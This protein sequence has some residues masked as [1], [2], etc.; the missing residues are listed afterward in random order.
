MRGS[1]WW[2]TVP[3]GVLG[4]DYTVCVLDAI[5]A[6][7]AYYDVDEYLA[8]GVTFFGFDAPLAIGTR[9]DHVFLL[10]LSA[11]AVDMIAIELGNQGV[12]VLSP[13]PALYDAMAKDAKVIGPH[14]IGSLIPGASNG[15]VGMTKHAAKLHSDAITRDRDCLSQNIVSACKTY[16]LHPHMGSIGG[17]RKGYACEYGWKLPGRSG[18]GHASHS[19]PGLY[20]VQNPQWAHSYR[21]FR[22]YSMGAV[23]VMREGQRRDGSVVDMREHV[24]AQSQ[25]PFILNPDCRIPLRTAERASRV[26]VSRVPF[27]APVLR[28]GSSGP[29]VATWQRILMSCGFDLAPYADDGDFGKLTHNA[30][31]GFQKERGLRASGVVNDTTWAMSAAAPIPR[32]RPTSD[33]TD[34]ILAK[35]FRWADRKEVDNICIHTIEGVEA[36]TTADRTAMW[37]QG[38]YT[39]APMAS[40]HYLFDDD[41]TI[42]G[43]PE[44]HIAF[45]APGLNHNGIHFEHAGY[46]RQTLEQW[47]DPFGRRMLSRSAKRAA[48]CCEAWD[49][50]P[51]FVDWRALNAGGAASRGITTHYQVTLGPGKGRTTHYDPGKA[52]PMSTYI[53]MVKQEMGRG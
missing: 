6:G 29:D 38:R 11:E 44:Q 17:N 45:C 37:F 15:S 10:G 21:N 34:T 24:Q 31:V 19:L 42:L 3:K 1:V 35:N 7:H 43:V 33:V 49:I 27:A 52:F 22:D 32:R 47:L 8:D 18:W 26:P 12:D 48:R 41:S 50:P 51:R 13:T 30:T 9:E 14:T 5:R 4:D 28:L 25:V 2:D 36:S 23:F 20:V 39:N 40:A 53:D 16:V 46:A